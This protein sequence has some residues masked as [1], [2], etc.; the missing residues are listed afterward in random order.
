MGVSY[1]IRG[2]RDLNRKFDDMYSILRV[3]VD[4]GVTIPKEVSEYFSQVEDE[5][6][7]LETLSRKDLQKYMKEVE[8]EF[9]GSIE[10]DGSAE[11]DLSKI[12]SDVKFIRI[13]MV[14]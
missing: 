6:Y 9:E 12:P 10:H 14:A 7:E 3:C 5:G 11:I 13:Y 2:V 4:G 8:I 1:V